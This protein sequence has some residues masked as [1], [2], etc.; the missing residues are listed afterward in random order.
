VSPYAVVLLDLDSETILYQQNID[1]KIYPA[2]TTKILTLIVAIE[3]S[4]MDDVVT[5]SSKAAGTKGSTL[6]LKT[7]EKVVMKDLL[8]GMM[9][10]SGN[11]AAIAVAEYVGESV[12]GFAEKMN[13]TAIRIGMSH[14]NFITPH[15]L[16][17]ENHYTT[18]R[19]MATLAIY[20]MR[21]PEFA[22]IVGKASYTMPADNKYSSTR[23]AK[24]TNHLLDTGSSDY[25]QYAT[26][27]KTG[28]TPK[29]GDCLVA[30]ASKDGMN[31]ICL[32]FKDEYNGSVR[33]GLAKTLFEWG[34]DNFKTVDLATLMK[35]VE[36]VQAT[37]E[38]A[39]AGDS[40][41]LEFNA[42][43]VGKTYVTLGKQAVEGILDGTDSVVTEKTLGED[44]LQAP[45]EK[46]AVVGT[47]TYKSANTGEV[48]YQGPLIAARD[49]KKQGTEP[50]ASGATAVETQ[51]PVA[52]PDLTTTEDNPLIWLWLIPVAGLIV[53]LVI[54]LATVNKRKRKRFKHRQPHYSYKIRKR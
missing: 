20:A 8:N 53:F 44:P 27:I 48:I 42:P 47:V 31:L 37:V 26:G 4:N 34:F 39:S 54:R 6:D 10:K 21:N 30:S 19:D 11:D 15:G 7:N 22:A 46:N 3:N 35:N 24:N 1:E 29:G 5:V 23:E 16:D 50:N 12:E 2:S 36:P 28:S 49:V 41:I 33:W 25:Y 51:T 43:E 45:I 14:S 32:V 9:M 38:N 40:G 18:A 17:N 13:A 52:P